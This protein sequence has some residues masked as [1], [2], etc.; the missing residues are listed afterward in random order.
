MKYLILD[1]ELSKEQ[2]KQ[3][4]GQLTCW[5]VSCDFLGLEKLKGDK[6]LLTKNASPKDAYGKCAILGYGKEYQGDAGYIVWDVEAITDDYLNLVYARYAKKPLEILT[7]DRLI[8]REMAEEDLQ[9]LYELYSYEHMTDYV[10]DLYEYDREL[11]FTRNYIKNMYGFFGYGLWLVF[12]KEDG[13]LIGRIGLENREI[14]GNVE[15]ELGY[16]VGS[17]FW[18]KGYAKE[19]CQ[20]IIDWAFDEGHLN[21]KRLFLCTRPDNQPSV[22]LAKSLGFSLY[23]ACVGDEHLDIYYKSK[24]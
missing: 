16:M 8:V 6:V 12:R 20:A 17:I 3:L 21:L 13:K 11:E 19:C 9:A 7:T 14:D 4:K 22:C 2:I 10:E 1:L 18:R 24:M 23:A 5:E 15:V